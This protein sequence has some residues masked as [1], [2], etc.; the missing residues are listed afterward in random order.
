MLIFSQGNCDISDSSQRKHT[1]KYGS[2]SSKRYVHLIRRKKSKVKTL[3][4]AVKVNEEF[5]NAV[6]SRLLITIKTQSFDVDQN[7]MLN[8]VKVLQNITY[9]YDIIKGNTMVL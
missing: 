2:N 7:K 5:E 8:Q 9:S 1:N 4:D 6:W 3:I